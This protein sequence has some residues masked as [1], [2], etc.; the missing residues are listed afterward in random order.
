MGRKG[1]R[2]SGGEGRMRGHGRRIGK[3]WSRG[4]ME[5]RRKNTILVICNDFL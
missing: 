2:K 5:R 4:R 1:L 3:E